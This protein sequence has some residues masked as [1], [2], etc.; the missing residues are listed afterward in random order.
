[1]TGFGSIRQAE[2][3]IVDDFGLAFLLQ[4]ITRFVLGKS[5]QG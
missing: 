5:E 3:P 4:Q 2:N 1:M